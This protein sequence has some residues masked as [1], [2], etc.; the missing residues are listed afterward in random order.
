MLAADNLLLTPVFHQFSVGVCFSTTYYNTTTFMVDVL[1]MLFGSSV[2]IDGVDFTRAS[3]KFGGCF[4]LHA[5]ESW[6]F[7]FNLSEYLGKK[8]ADYQGASY[9]DLSLW[10]TAVRAH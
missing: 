4:N 9:T 1:E 8:K 2:K 10:R 6:T 5:G 7:D 3:I